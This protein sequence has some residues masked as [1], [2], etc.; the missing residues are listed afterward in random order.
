MLRNFLAVFLI[1]SGTSIA[2]AVPPDEIAET[3]SRAESLYYEA[4]FKDAIQLLQRVDDLL[5]PRTDRTQEKINVKL[6]L[7]L[8]LVG[9]N[10]I[11][12]A[13]ASLREI[14][15]IEPD[16]RLDEQ[17]F[18]PKIV[19]LA[20]E[21]RIEQSQLRCQAVRDEARNYFQKWDAMGL[22]N[23]IQSM[24]PK[25]NG[26]EALEPDA[27][28]L[29]YKNGVDAYKAGQFADALGKFRMAV[30]LSPRHEL[31]AQY[32]ELTQSKLQMD[33]DRLVLEWRKT[34]QTGQFKQAADR[35]N[36][37][38]RTDGV[39]PQMLDQ[40]RSEYR[41]ALTP[42]VESWNRAC[43]SSDTFTMES[44]RAQVPESLPESQLGE[45]ILA[46]MKTCTKKGCLQMGPQLALA[47]LKVQV[48][49]VIPPAFQDA[50]RR[51]PMTIRVKSR[52]DEKGDVTAIEA[53]GGTPL[54]N[55]SVRNAVEHWK[56]APIVDQSGPRCVE[57]DIPIT[58][59]P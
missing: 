55:E 49:P 19:M 46:Q 38:K 58:L 54:I 6:Q 2:T 1:L 9:L 29:L 39:T 45:D 41:R 7:A 48:N 25:C 30:K 4:K 47:R 13:K 59:K 40:M 17:Q 3:L 21:A 20:D 16:Y 10:N 27:A 22:V 44:L 51:G 12:D 32:L 18:P 28:E 53:Q 50:A 34:L 14:F 26:L 23:L 33:G 31:A 11:A 5:R 35:F 37:L 57:T 24:K 8:S 36:V 52:I 56:F 43:A 15:V 42:I